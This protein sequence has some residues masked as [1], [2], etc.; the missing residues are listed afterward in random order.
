[1]SIF[2]IPALLNSISKQFPDKLAVVHETKNISFEELRSSAVSLSNI[3]KQI[4]VNKGDRIGICMNKNIDQVIVILGSMYAN[5]IFVPVLP[6][7]KQDNIGHIISDS[8]MR[9]I[10][11]EP[12]RLSEVEEFK[13][14]VTILTAN[15]IASEGFMNLNPLV[16]SVNHPVDF[17]N[18]ISEDAAGIIYSSGS[19]G[20]PKG[21]V[22]SHRNFYDGA[23]IVSKYL[24]TE[25]EDRIAGVLS[26]NFDYGLNQIWQTIYKGATLY[27]HD[28]LLPNDFFAFIDRWKI[29]DLPLMPV[30]ISRI[31]DPRFYNPN[32][33]FDLSSV[34]YV[35]SSGGRVS[36]IMVDNLKGA[37]KQS[38]IFLM[39]GLTEA[40]RSTFLP[41]EQ[42]D[43]R[44]GSIGKAIPESEIYVLDDQNNDCP[45]GV[46]GELV[47]R[48]GCI[49]K[50]YWNDKEKTAERFKIID[51]FP[52]ERVVFSGDLVKTDEEGFIYFI[53][54]KDNMLKNSGIRISPSEVEETVEKN[55]QIL[56]SVVFGIENI[57]VGHDLVLVYRTPGKEPLVQGELMSFLKENLPSHMVPKYQLHMPEFPATGNEGKIDRVSVIEVAKKQLGFS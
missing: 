26:F 57:E 30:I 41:P 9:F 2:S 28:L 3:F 22:T 51:R 6:R 46:A 50:G 39:Y 36:P 42:I 35:C 13:D 40:F 47:H 56:S 7:L 55:K 49:S 4:G 24:G 25:H 5:A 37:F 15:E 29:T 54:R 17:F 45:P 34:K 38:R 21:I 19:T 11:T 44:S 27:L 10:V 32:K 18:A 16:K 12:S 20:R 1:M 33:G 52:G 8:G 31:F 53:S 43:L 23:R 48:G 14:K